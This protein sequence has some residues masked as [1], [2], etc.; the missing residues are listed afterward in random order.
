MTEGWLLLDCETVYHVVPGFPDLSVA[1][2]HELNGYCWCHPVNVA[3]GPL[4]TPILSHNDA[5]W[6]GSDANRSTGA[7]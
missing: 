4:D 7:N 2:E 6:P 1:N 5:T 3:I